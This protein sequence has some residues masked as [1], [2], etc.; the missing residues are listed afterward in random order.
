[1]AGLRDLLAHAYFDLDDAILWDTLQYKI[2][3]LEQELLHE[4]KNLLKS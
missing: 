1:M 3:A 2:P 4:R